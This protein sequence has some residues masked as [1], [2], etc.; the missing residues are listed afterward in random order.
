MAIGEVVI[1]SFLVSFFQ[2]LFNKLTSLALCHVQREGIS[3]TL[4]EK[5]KAMLVTING[6]LADAEDKQLGDNPQMKLWLDNVRDLAYDMEDLLN[7]FAIKAAQVESEAKSNTIRDLEK[8]KFSFFGKLRSLMS[9]NKVQEINGRL[10]TIITGKAHLSLREN[11]ADKLNYTSKRDPTTSLPEPQFFCREKEEAHILELLIG[12]VENSDPTLSI[13]PIIGMGCIG[14]TALAQRLYN[15]AIVNGY[16]GRR[17]WVCV[18]NIFY[19]LDITKIILRSITSLSYEGEDLN[20]LQVKWKD[21]LSRKKFLVVLDDVWNGN[22]EKWTNLLKP[23]EVGAKGS[24][25]IVMTHNLPVW[26][27]IIFKDTYDGQFVAMNRLVQGHRNNHFF[28]V[29]HLMTLYRCSN[30]IRCCIAK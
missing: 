28:E 13:V 1:G 7:E 2:I 16:F 18:S 19:V 6:V 20:R 23:F 3:T 8:W 27:T 25:I 11:V 15:D 29:C 14:K 30:V 26:W 12:E 24:K 17:A 10:K 22:Y 4:L 9:E 21:N 5:W